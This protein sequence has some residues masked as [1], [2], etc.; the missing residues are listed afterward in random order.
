MERVIHN[1]RAD[2]ALLLIS[3]LAEV[4]MKLGVE[5]LREKKPNLEIEIL[6]VENKFFG[7]SILTA[8]LL[9]VE[10]FRTALQ[11]YKDRLA[12]IDLILLPKIAFNYWG[13]DLLDENYYQLVEEFGI[14][15]E[16][17]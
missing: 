6:A 3:Q 7:G 11:E 15:V 8:G 1:Y 4:R 17:I 13:L 9:V 12:E 2:K 5:L 14:E 16:I 10:D